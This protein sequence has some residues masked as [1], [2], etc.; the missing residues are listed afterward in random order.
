VNGYLILWFHFY[1][2]LNTQPATSTQ[3]N[4]H[5]HNHRFEMKLSG[6][7][8]SRVVSF[9]MSSKSQ[10]TISQRIRSEPNPNSAERVGEGA[11]MFCFRVSLFTENRL[12]SPTLCPSLSNCR[13]I[14]L[15]P[16][17]LFSPFVLLSL[18]PFRSLQ[19]SF[20]LN[21]QSANTTETIIFSVTKKL[22]H[23]V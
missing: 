12:P 22:L 19:Y 17:A 8:M 7:L 16:T 6:E 5:S 9:S 2:T 15:S 10:T 18:S 13:A 21:P 4:S 23:E 3:T 1:L 11:G 20:I 14:L